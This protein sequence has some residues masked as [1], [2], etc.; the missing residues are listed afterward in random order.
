LDLLKGR[1]DGCLSV[2]AT[3][4]PNVGRQCRVHTVRSSAAGN[5][6]SGTRGYRGW[7]WTE[8]R[9]T[10]RDVLGEKTLF[11]ENTMPE[12]IQRTLL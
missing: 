12:S 11:R 4:A 6:P 9:C 5:S 10:R 8:D 3:L 2:D 7:W 1:A